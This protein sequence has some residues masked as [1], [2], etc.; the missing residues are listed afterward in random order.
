MA[1]CSNCGVE[2][3]DRTQRCPLCHSVLAED[4]ALENMYPD[5]R[6]K[7]RR[8]MLA[9]HIYL[10]CAIIAVAVLVIVE[11]YIDPPLRWSPVIGLALLY[12]YMILRYAILGRSGYRSKVLVLTLLGLSLA[13]ASDMLMG[14]RGW[15]VDYVLPASILF[16]DIGIAVLM[17]INHRAWHSYIMLQLLMIVCSL[18]PA[19]LYLLELEHNVCM[20]FLPLG[21]SLALFLG[22]VIIGDR[23]AL[24]ELKRRF[25]IN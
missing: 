24:Q 17:I 13:V 22:T 23:P 19:A 14:Y 2:I 3:L 4:T 5:I 11:L 10:F 18:I 7:M 25:H 6:I 8:L 12:V 21:A 15:S 9:A 20:A 16:I 1:K